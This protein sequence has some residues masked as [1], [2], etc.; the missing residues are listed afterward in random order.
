MFQ[1]FAFPVSIG[2]FTIAN[3]GGCGS[4]YAI[5]ITS[6]AFKGLNTVKQHRLVNETLKKEIEGIHGLQVSDAAN[7]LFT[8]SNSPLAKNISARQLETRYSVI[9]LCSTRSQVRPQR[10][11]IT[12]LSGDPCFV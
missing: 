6:N 8:H 10:G 5:S 11:A 2:C 9:S 12:Q 3:P 7:V 1:V 4:F